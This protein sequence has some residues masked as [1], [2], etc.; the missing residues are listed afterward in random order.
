[1]IGAEKR[2]EIAFLRRAGGGDDGRAAPFGDLQGR[3]PDAAGTTM[4]Q[5]RLA[6]AKRASSISA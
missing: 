1:M 4:D 5:H 6:L 3:E 2:Q